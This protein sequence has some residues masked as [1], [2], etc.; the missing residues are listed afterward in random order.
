[1]KKIIKNI[2]NFFLDLLYTDKAGNIKTVYLKDR[3][4]LVWISEIVGRRIFFRMFEKEETKFFEEHIKKG[5]ICLDVGCNIGYFTNLFASKVGKQGKV[6]SI[7]AIQ[8]NTELVKL[9]STLN[10]TEEIINVIWTA[11]GEE[12]GKT[13]QLNETDDTGLVY[14]N[15]NNNQEIY[16]DIV[17]SVTKKQVKIST[18]DSILEAEKIDKVDVLKMDIEGYEYFALQGMKKYL[19][20]SKGPRIMMLELSSSHLSMHGKSVADVIKMLSHSYAPHVLTS[21]LLVPY[22]KELNKSNVFFVKDKVA[23]SQTKEQIKTTSSEAI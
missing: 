11:V 5:D 12:D 8:K 14:I 23:H 15:G 20:S 7:D 18:I 1:M 3:I 4:Q 6:I 2:F 17:K 21:G 19:T 16:T 22:K 13:V 9:N 10:N